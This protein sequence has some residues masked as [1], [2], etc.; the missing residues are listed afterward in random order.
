MTGH[1]DHPGTGYTAQGDEAAEADIATIV[2]ALGVQH[3]RSI[4]P[5]DLSAVKDAIKWGLSLDEPAVIIARWPCAL[6]R[7]TQ[8]DRDEFSVNKKAFAIDPEAC[9]G[10]KKCTKTGCPAL[11]YD[12]AQKKASIY[13]PSCDGCSICAQTCPAG[14]ISR[15]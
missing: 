13:A 10:C 1:Q 2:K 12:P 4:N 11:R 5:T 8:K 7:S 3:I 14:A 9:I 15:D 6:K